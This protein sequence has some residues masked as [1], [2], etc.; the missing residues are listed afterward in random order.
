M[1]EETM[2]QRTP[3]P[4]KDEFAPTAW[5]SLLRVGF[6]LLVGC[7]ASTAWWISEKNNIQHDAEVQLA[8][9]GARLN[10]DVSDQLSRIEHL[11]YG[12]RGLYAVNQQVDQRSWNV[13]WDSGDAAAVTGLRSLTFFRRVPRSEEAA[14]VAEMR[15]QL[16]PQFRLQREEG[17]HDL[18]V[19]VFRRAFPPDRDFTGLDR[20]TEPALRSSA[21]L[22]RHTG[23]VMLTGPV[24]S[25][26]DPTDSRLLLLLPLYRADQPTGTEAERNAAHHGWISAGI[27]PQD[28]FTSTFTNLPTG[29]V[30]RLE[31]ISDPQAPQLL[32]DS[33]VRRPIRDGARIELEHTFYGRTLKF[34]LAA[35]PGS[36]GLNRTL[37]ANELFFG[38]LL[39]SSLIGLLIWSTMRTERHSRRIADQ[40]TRELHER[41]WILQQAQR[42]AHIGT[43]IYD[44][45]TQT[46]VCSDECCRIIGV[47]PGAAS[48]HAPEKFL[49]ML[50]GDDRTLART[51]FA[52]MQRG[53]AA[54]PHRL[55]LL[56]PDKG[57]RIIAVQHEQVE[58]RDASTPRVIATLQD[59]TDRVA[60]DQALTESHRRMENLMRAIPGMIFQLLRS[61]TG[62]FTVPFVSE[63]STAL[64]GYPPSQ[65]IDQPETL[66][67]SVNAEGT[68][69]FLRSLEASAET[70]RPWHHEVKIVRLDGGPRWVRFNAVPMRDPERNALVW[71]GV[72]LDVTETKKAEQALRDS[73]Q[74]LRMTQ[75]AVDHVRDAVAFI[76][77]AGERIYVNDETCR[78]T[79]HTREELLQSKIWS[80]FTAFTAETYGQLWAQVKNRGTHVFEATLQTRSGEQRSVEVSLSFIGFGGQE[81]VF[82]IARDISARKEAEKSLRD[83]EERLRFTR[84]AL[85]HAHDV[86]SIVSRDGDRLYVNDTFCQFHNRSREELFQAKVWDSIPSLNP[87]RYRALW[88]EIKRRQTL[89][90]EIEIVSKSGE[91]KPLE[92]N[93]SYINFG[94]REAVCTISRDI[95]A[96]R[97]AE[98]E[99]KRIQ[100]QLQETQ[101]LES[102]G[103]LAGGIAHDFNNLL[104]GVLGNAS[105]ARDRLGEGSDLHEPLR[106]IERAAMRAAEL[107]QQMLAYAGKGRFVVEPVNLSA[108]VEDM[109]KLLDLSVARRAHLEL[110]LAP[111]LPA[112]M[113]DA[114]QIRQIVMNLVLNAAEA[115]N[116]VK[117]QITVVTGRIQVDRKFLRTARVAAELAEGEGVFLE[118]SD[119]GSGMDRQ[120]LERIF[121]PFFTTKFTGRGLGLAAVL[122]IVRSH[123]GALQVTSDLGQGTSFKLVLASNH[124]TAPTPAGTPSIFPPTKRNQGRIF[125]IDDEESVR[126]VTVQALERTGFTVETAADGEAAIERLRQTPQAF[127]VILLDYTMP[128]LDG[129]ETLR[130]IH[131]ISPNAKVILMS[132]FPEQEARERIGE[133]SLAGFIQKPFDIGTLRKRVEEIVQAQQA[134]QPTTPRDQATGT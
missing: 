105:L 81:M 34:Q 116:Q 16:G 100:Q 83:S 112:V 133:L 31:D 132:G 122:G 47:P 24:P 84:Y 117:G 21:E 54:A 71:N 110:R 97:A 95:T 11:L 62:S 52:Q 131:R 91:T 59:I 4:P 18:M 1:R 43:C 37:Q 98:L 36:F 38:G 113:A 93:A 66:F 67:R 121:E 30:L 32:Y 5:R 25:I 111:N 6:V 60:A 70:L 49:A 29:L 15:R 88:D 65:M 106:Q 61:S 50:H 74:R 115:M 19:I 86:V 79:G 42:I 13:Y 123:R 80:T 63:G 129:A 77:P 76:G 23:Q 120:T 9:I 85:D 2:S 119:N 27:R 118:V 128:R 130:E 75:F 57:L 103:V 17:S 8:S 41:E 45:A 73:E 101:K 127:L 108:L 126:S 114:T 134:Q 72:A 35:L 53:E 124:Q 10:F 22:T 82:A 40:M 58:K 33:A 89:T 3:S 55:R 20:S 102:L 46:Y 26:M 96:R 92:V 109:A 14:F 87:E 28:F 99:K 12:A 44:V 125:V 39:V 104:T 69:E 107:C 56:T 78:L 7:G 48:A 90:Y 94:G 64:F 68:G 51:A